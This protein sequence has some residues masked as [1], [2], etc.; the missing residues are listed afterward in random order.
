MYDPCVSM[1]IHVYALMCGCMHSWMETGMLEVHTSLIM[2]SIV[3]RPMGSMLGG[4]YRRCK[5][6]ALHCEIQ[7][8]N[9]LNRRWRCPE[10]CTC[11]VWRAEIILESGKLPARVVSFIRAFRTAPATFFLSESPMECGPT[12]PIEA[13][14][15]SFHSGP[16]K[17]QECIL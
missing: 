2:Q 11:M 17:V 8:Y 3:R 12:S 9:H 1:C 16:Q 6:G 15:H 10:C 13:F 4:T 7:K 14:C 5:V